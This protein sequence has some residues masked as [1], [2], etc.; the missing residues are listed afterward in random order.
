MGP[1][2]DQIYHQDPA[3]RP[4]IWLSPAQS[5]HKASLPAQD[6]GAE[7]SLHCELLAMYQSWSQ[8]PANQ[9]LQLMKLTYIEASIDRA[10]LECITKVT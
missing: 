9:D 6:V 3:A 2:Y 5:S 8:D 4:A 1:T 10:M 7:H